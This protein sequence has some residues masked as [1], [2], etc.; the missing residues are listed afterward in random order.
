MGTQPE[1]RLLFSMGWPI[2]LS[3]LVQ[4][5]YNVVDTYFVSQTADAV[6]SKAALGF[7]Y[8]IQMLMIAFSIGTAVGM[9][10]LISRRL[11]AG[12]HDEANGAA[13][14]GIMLLILTSLCFALVGIFLSKPIMLIMTT[15]PRVIELGT[16]YL[17]I[18]CT[19][20]MGSFV[21]IGL[22]RVMSAQGKTLLTMAMQLSGGVSNIVLDAILVPHYGVEGAAIATVLGQTISMVLSILIL[23]LG[24][25]EVSI[26]LRRMRLKKD[27]VKNIYAVG[28]PS[29]VM[30]AIGVVMMFG[31]DLIL[32]GLAP[33]VGAAVF[34]VYYKL[35]S[36]IFMPI[37][38]MTNASMSI[39]GY[40]YGARNKKRLL[41]VLKL[42]LCYSV[43]V[44]VLGTVVFQLFPNELLKIFNSTAVELEIG[45]PALRIVSLHFIIAAVSI[46]LSTFF[47]AI[48]K[49]LNSMWISLIRQ[50]VVLLPAA[51][52]LSKLTGNI[53]AVWWAYPIAE[54]AS[55]IIA[56]LLF[57][58]T[59]LKD[60]K[61][62]DVPQLQPSD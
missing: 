25:H 35:Q 61:T 39:E 7:A 51:F 10:S 43:C 48:G 15:D 55:L 52:I 24:K 45:V 26:K 34:G 32:E 18:C 59:Y 28:I 53:A 14:N 36:I 16:R 50:L 54:V 31:M 30:Q 5:F 60:L 57:V 46:S 40:N 9:N 1:G 62:L 29:I 4:A 49:G 17:F 11:G 6:Y 58:R 2:I 38:G 21:A 3:M 8:P 37:F 20:S 56:V 27:S 47:G 23:A 33:T 44:M 41:Q 13:A 42:T 19:F 22:E 12:R